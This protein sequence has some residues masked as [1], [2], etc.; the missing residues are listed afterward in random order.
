[1]EGPKGTWSDADQRRQA[2]RDLVQ[3]VTNE[4]PR[5]VSRSDLMPRHFAALGLARIAR[6]VDGM[7]YL[8]DG[9]HADVMDAY[10]RSVIE[11]YALSLYSLYGGPNPYE[12]IR[13]SHV[14]DVGLLPESPEFAR[15]KQLRERWEGRTDKI[16]WEQLIKRDLPPLVP[17]GETAAGRL[18]FEQMYDLM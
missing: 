6:L 9:D 8:Y 13:G 14:R 18:W 7:L 11:V 4:L 2:V 16:A 5:L 17:D 15:A 3:M 10:G 12:H 1:M